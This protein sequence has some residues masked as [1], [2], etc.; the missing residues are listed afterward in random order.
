MLLEL[1]KPIAFWLV[2]NYISYTVFATIL[3]QGSTL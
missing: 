1:A 2:A 3:C